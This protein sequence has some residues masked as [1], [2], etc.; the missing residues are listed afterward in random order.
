[1]DTVSTTSLPNLTVG[2][3]KARTD[4]LSSFDEYLATVKPDCQFHFAHIASGYYLLAADSSSQ[5]HGEFGTAAPGFPGTILE[6][7]ASENRKDL[8]FDLF[9]DPVGFLRTGLGLRR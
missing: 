5:R 2:L 9:P 4:P 6:L 3:E 7:Q 8:T 1:M